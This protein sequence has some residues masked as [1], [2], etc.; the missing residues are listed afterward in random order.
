MT[1]GRMVIAPNCGAYP[2]SWLG[3]HNLFY[4][5]GDATSLASKLEE[6]AALD[7]NDIGREN[8]VNCIEVELARDLSHMSGCRGASQ[9]NLPWQLTG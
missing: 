9:A 4:E 3:T 1:F 8:A 5:A 6:A 7:T 2:D